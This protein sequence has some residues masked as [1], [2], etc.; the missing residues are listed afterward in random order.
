MGVISDGT[1]YNAP[2]DVIFSFPVTVKL[3]T[4][5]WQIVDNVALDDV[6]KHW[7][8]AT[9]DELVEERTEALAAS[10]NS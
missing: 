5:D 10:S 6:A 2:K 9:G 7:I 1:K 3:Q 8:K 4:K